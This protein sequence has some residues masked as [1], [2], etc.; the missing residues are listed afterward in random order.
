MRV[1]GYSWNYFGE[2]ALLS[3]WVRVVGYFC[4]YGCVEECGEGYWCMCSWKYMGYLS[5]GSM[6]MR[7]RLVQ[8]KWAV[9]Y[10]GTMMMPLQIE[11]ADNLNSVLCR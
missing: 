1:G 9:R 5:R 3:M 7:V 4:E 2:G 10:S 8:C 6:W 11:V